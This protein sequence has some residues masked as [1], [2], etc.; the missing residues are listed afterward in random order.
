MRENARRLGSAVKQC[1]IAIVITTLIQPPA[2][3]GA[4]RIDIATSALEFGGS[5]GKL[6]WDTVDARSK[7]SEREASQYSKLAYNVK[8]QIDLGRASSSILKQSF[9]TLGTTLSY[10]A[11]VDPEPLSKAV[12][13]IAAWGAKK[14][15]DALGQMV[16]DQSQK[17]AQAI[18]AQGLKNSGLSQTQLK[19]MPAEEL[20]A[21]VADLRVGGQTLREILK[22]DPGSLS[23]LQAHATDIA[24]D[25]GVA[26]L[27]QSKGTAADVKTIQ[28]DLAKTT[29][30][31]DNY[32]KEV[33]GHL[34]KIDSGISGLEDATRV[35]NEKLGELKETIGVNSKAIQTMAQISYSG[36]ST[37]QK[38]QA[39]NGG[40]F[41]NLDL[42]QKEALVQSLKADQVREETVASV[43]QAAKDFGNLAAIAGN[44]GLPKDIVK[45][46]GDAQKAAT[47]IVQFASGDVL[48]SIASITSLVGLGAPDAAAERHAAMMKYLE[49][50]FSVVNQKLDRIIELQIQTL[51]AVAALADEQR[52]FRKEVL[53]QLDRV[54]DTV[55]RSERVLQAILASQ[56]TEC[57]ALINGTKLN[58]QFNIPTRE[59]LIE[60]VTNADTP[61]NA[62][63]CY[64]RMVGFLEAWVKPAKWSGQIIDASNFPD[65]TIPSESVLQRALVAFQS[66]RISAYQ[67]ARDF[68][69]QDLRDASASPAAYVARFA[70]PVVDSNFANELDSALARK[71]IQ[72]QF[73]SFKCNQTDLL[74]PALRELLCFG[75]VDRSPKPPLPA[76]WSDLLGASLI[77]PWSTGLVETGITLSTIADF[78]EANDSG[79]LAFVNSRMIEEFSKDGP[80]LELR[81]ALAQRKGLKLLEEL[82]WLTEASLLQQSITYG[83][84]TAQLVEK[85]L[86]DGA[87]KSLNIDPKVPLKQQALLAMRSNPILAR[88]VILLAM[89][90][91]I[92][93]ALGGSQKA[94]SSNYLQTYY[95]LALLDF[96][97]TQRCS[98][99]ASQKLGELFPNWKFEYRVTSLQKKN[100]KGLEECPTEFEP[101]PNN[102]TPPPALGSGV[103]AT[104]S[105]FYVLVP[106]PLALGD[107]V[108]EQPDSLRNALADRDRLSQAI[109]DRTVGASVRDASGKGTDSKGVAAGIAFALLNEGWGWHNRTTSK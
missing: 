101:D 23:I 4:E 3:V 7:V 51:K 44:L 46:L 69:L 17:Q 38:L 105:D 95:N 90:H 97:G 40:L 104:I 61:K 68:V 102:S 73:Q 77:G 70:Q 96:T 66:Q 19:N 41:P 25:I 106:S 109:I 71:E 37:T 89:R 65:K 13:G 59:V 14:T 83:D 26:A 88:N 20:G 86:Y 74:A 58:G 62:A 27:A 54:E 80:T 29:R 39:V 5:I 45:G 67:N 81:R 24:T 107:G 34:E 43:Q 11:T 22:D 108:F 64:S 76:R 99:L 55:L 63:A 75:M 9:N 84:Y 57:H 15:G 48:G 53:G 21:K 32:Q 10:A 82:R 87:T 18:L 49:Q 2:A 50:Q 78:A 8:D 103:A 60:V 42:K 52:Q 98:S 92:S 28:R 94:A 72:I 91:A 1:I 56:W 100:E 16:I 33:Q 35:A 79:S 36:W 47:A 31:I 30:E 12:S 6:L 93:D 85:A